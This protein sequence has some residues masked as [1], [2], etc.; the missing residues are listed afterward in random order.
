M[1]PHISSWKTLW[2][3]LFQDLYLEENY[4]FLIATLSLVLKHCI[5]LLYKETLGEGFCCCCCCFFFVLFCFVFHRLVT[6]YSLGYSTP[7]SVGSLIHN[8]HT[9]RTLRTCCSQSK[10]TILKVRE[11]SARALF[12]C[13]YTPNTSCSAD[14]LESVV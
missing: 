6:G 9:P 2:P 11:I 5:I 12:L 7:F 13:S 14:A 10:L 8:S 4:A 3:Q 1:W